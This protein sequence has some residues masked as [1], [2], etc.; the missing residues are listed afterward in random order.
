MPS[1]AIGYGQID[2]NDK[3]SL[4]D[5]GRFAIARSQNRIRQ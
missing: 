2:G 1:R 5:A 3:L 4:T